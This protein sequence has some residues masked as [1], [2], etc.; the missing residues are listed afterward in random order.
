MGFVTKRDDVV[1]NLITFEKHLRSRK[2]K[3]KDWAVGELLKADKVVIYKVD[4]E[5]HF[6]PAGFCAHV[7]N[8]IEAYEED[9]TE[10]KDIVKTLTKIIG[11]SFYN[12]KTDEKHVEYA[13]KY[14]KATPNQN[15]D[16]WRVK[17]ERGKNYN[18]KWEKV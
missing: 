3:E 6:A 15:R 1:D 4:G 2:K 18:V 17:D 13:A 8:S 12:E 11:N 9:T 5:N 10:M 16:F 7:D 14:G